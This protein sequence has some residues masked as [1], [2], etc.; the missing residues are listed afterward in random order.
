ME[1]KIIKEKITKEKLKEIV[2][3]NYGD[4]TKAVVDIEKKIIAIGGEFH[5]DASTILV[6]KE[7]SN[8]ENVWGFN[9]YPDREDRL[10]FDSLI[11]IKPN[12]GNRDVIIGSDKIKQRIRNIVKDLIE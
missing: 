8:Y 4:M 3:E 9:V 11:N 6:E 2:K 10:E 12:K 1:I 7:G 5:S